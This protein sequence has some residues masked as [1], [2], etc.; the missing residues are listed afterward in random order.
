MRRRAAAAAV[1]ACVLV[2]FS[3][4]V[5]GAAPAPSHDPFASSVLRTWVAHRAGHAT[6]AV[7]D[8]ETGRSSSSTPATR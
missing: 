8:I 7:Y 6:A 5:A 4:A 3:T 1:A 2:A